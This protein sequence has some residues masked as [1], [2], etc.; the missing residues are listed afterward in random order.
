MARFARAI[1]YLILNKI[2]P[3]KKFNLIT[4]SVTSTIGR[5]LLHEND[6]YA[7][8]CTSQTTLLS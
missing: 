7:M 8:V 3:A 1:F 2:Q 5:G 4:R 6:F